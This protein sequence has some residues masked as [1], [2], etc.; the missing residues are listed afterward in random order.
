MSFVDFTR[1]GLGFLVGLVCL[2]GCDGGPKRTFATFAAS[3][4]EQHD[5][6]GG[7]T[8]KGPPAPAADA[9]ATLTQESESVAAPPGIAPPAGTASESSVSEPSDGASSFAPSA[10][11]A[12]P[13]EGTAASDEGTAAAN[14]GQTS[15]PALGSSTVDN[16]ATTS[17]PA[18]L[19]DSGLVV[20]GDFEAGKDGWTADSTYDA[21]EQRVHPLVVRS[22]D[23]TVASFSVTAQ[24]GTGF[25]Y[26]GGV[27][28]DEYMGYRTRLSQRIFVPAEAQGL[29][30][31]GYVWVETS[32]PPDAEYDYAYVQLEPIDE[33]DKVQQFAFWTN[34]DASSGWTRIDV[35]LDSLSQLRGDEVDFVVEA[36]TDS[37]TPTRFWFD[38]LE[39]VVTCP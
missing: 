12:A 26:L 24:G 18:V 15:G 39:L 36:R 13:D 27:P 8:G 1:G 4:V 21:F 17:P 14:D 28:D 25:A 9:S 22:G 38:S 5:A 11:T 2:Q 37:N 29:I 7:E 32:E 31:R 10:S 30:L 23:Q 6:D 35:Y 3:G 20:N 34:L 33:S 16:S 19:C